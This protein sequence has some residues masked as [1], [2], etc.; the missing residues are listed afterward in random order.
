M[1]EYADGATPLDPDESEGLL[2]THITT[3][4]EL[5]RWESD[6]I[7]EADRWLSRTRKKSF[8]N[9]DFIC[10]LHKKM[11]GNVW[12]WAGKFRTSDKNIGVSPVEI[13]VELKKLCDDAEAWREFGTYPPDE[14]AARFHHRLV[15]IHPF[16]NG[17]GR[18][19]RLMAD[20][21]LEKVFGRPRFTWGRKSGLETA[22]L[23]KRYITALKDA[24]D[25]DYSK[26]FAFVRS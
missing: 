14:F 21:I 17:N 8:L 24:D 4:G 23:R 13:A 18:H 7:A 5:D 9:E 26:L 19:A 6:N 22:E 16:P 15:F 3:R 20:F 2:L 25:F 12:A 1:I 10:L 11:Y